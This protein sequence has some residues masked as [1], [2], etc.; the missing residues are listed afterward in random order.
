MSLQSGCYIELVR[1]A[2]FEWGTFGRLQINDALSLATIEPPW[3]N[4][5]PEISCVPEG[6]YELAR[7]QSPK[8]GDCYALIGDAVSL[9]YAD[10]KRW[11]ILIHPANWPDEL[12]GCIAPGLS[13]GYMPV[14]RDWPRCMGVTRSKQAMRL[15]QAALPDH[16]HLQIS[17]VDAVM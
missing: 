2:Y 16:C 4:N 15:L 3:R 7:H 10:N 13:I 14:A 6:S 5:Q 17:H 8:F 12:R 1:L 9:E 11:G